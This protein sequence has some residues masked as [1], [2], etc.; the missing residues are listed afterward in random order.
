MIA[1]TTCL[2]CCRPRVR[3]WKVKE[4]GHQPPVEIMN[5]VVSVTSSTVDLSKLN[6]ESSEG[7][8]N[9]A[10]TSKSSEAIVT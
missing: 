8:A 5:A 7:F 2:L 3:E 4:Q 1:I 6:N 10:L 9:T